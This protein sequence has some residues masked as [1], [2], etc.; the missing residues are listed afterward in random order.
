[1]MIPV[2]WGK[3]KKVLRTWQASWERQPNDI[4]YAV[5]V[6]GCAEMGGLDDMADKRREVWL[7]S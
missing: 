5:E 3:A 7:R 2:F 1:M 6:S 4:K